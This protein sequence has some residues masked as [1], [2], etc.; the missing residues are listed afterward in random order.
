MLLHSNHLEY[1]GFMQLLR[2]VLG[3]DSSSLQPLLSRDAYAKPNRRLINKQD[4][5]GRTP[6]P[7]A[8]WRGDLP[9]VTVLLAYQD[10][11]S[12]I[13]DLQGFTPLIK[14]AS[15]GH[16]EFVQTLHCAKAVI[17][18]I[19]FYGAR[20]IHLASEHNEGFPIVGKL[21]SYCAN[22]NTASPEGTPLHYAA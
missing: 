20:E 4:I 10:T 17:Q 2:I 7:W 3:L 15:R 21:V 12:N 16:L 5:K 6:L 18:P 9:T 19:L 22:L 13:L 11:F 8:A 14:A 1:Q